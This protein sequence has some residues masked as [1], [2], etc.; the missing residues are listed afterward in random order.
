M[1]FVVLHNHIFKNAGSSIDK[2]FESAGFSNFRMD[3]P[4]FETVYPDDVYRAVSLNS[5]IDYISS[6]VFRVPRPEDLPG[7][8]F[9]D[10]TFLRHPLDRLYS[11][12]SYVRRP[13]VNDFPG[14]QKSIDF[15]QFIDYLVDSAPWHVYSPQVIA[16]GGRRDFYFPPSLAHLNAASSAVLQTRFLGVVDRFVLSFEVFLHYAGNLVPLDRLPFL[17]G[18]YP[19]ENRSAAEVIPVA[20]RIEFFEAKLGAERLAFLINSNELDLRL[21]SCAESELLRRASLIPEFGTS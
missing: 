10:I 11:I 14:L 4:D 18:P 6:H 17:R 12:Y 13:G 19:T 8:G 2:I 7:L 21:Y 16:L 1:R 3:G 15:A 9:I 5:S 20:Q